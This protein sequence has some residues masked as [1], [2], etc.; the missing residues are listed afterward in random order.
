MPKESIRNKLENILIKKNIGKTHLGE[1]Y[2]I[3]FLPVNFPLDIRSQYSEYK[4]YI[5]ELGSG[6]GEFTREIAKQNP[7]SLIIALEKKKKRVV[8]CVKWQK[9]EN[10]ENIRW[11]I[12]DITWFF[13]EI[14]NKNSFDKIIIN[15]PDPWP[16]KRHHK[17]R[18]MTDDFIE[19]LFTISKKDTLLEFAT[20]FWPYM[21]DALYS[22]ELSGKWKNIHGKGILLNDIPDRPKSY[23]EKLKLE[24]GENTYF[25][26]MKRV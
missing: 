17:K 18:F 15:F 7:N 2:T 21:Q 1:N 22:L 25:L 16:K 12:V 5:L 8:R 14:F 13:K 19:I 6:W 24:E 20:D 9:K 23:F 4:S 11:M 3:D 10:I 26:Q